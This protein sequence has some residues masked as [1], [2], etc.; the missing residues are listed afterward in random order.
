MKFTKLIL[1]NVF[2]NKLRAFLTALLIATIF[3]FVATLL[4]IL[5]AFEHFSDSGKGYNRLAVQSA[6]SL[7]TPLPYSHEPKLRQIP[8][9][10]DVCK[11]QWIGGIY[12]D[13]KNFFANFAVDHD[14]METVFEDY[15]VD[16]KQMADFKNDRQGALIGDDLPKRFGWKIGDRITLKGPLFGYDPQITIR[17]IYHHPVNKSALYYHMDYHQ[18]MIGNRGW[19]GTYWLNVKDPAQMASISQQI[20]AMFKN[21]EFPTE[22]F[23]EKE[24]QKN[25]V[26]MMGNI[27]LMFTVICICAIFMVVLLAAITMSMTARERVTEI[28]VLKAIGFQRG[29]VMRL[30][31]TEFVVLTLFGGAVGAFGA[32]LL[33][34]AVDMAQATQGFLTN[35]TVPTSTIVTCLAI[36]AG[37]GLLS[38]GIPALRA[39]GM[40]VVNGLRRV[41]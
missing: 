24:F 16:P 41:V 13:P 35:F 8:G 26:S 33:F 5:Y 6:I 31:L 11:L 30:M 2:R 27:K 25:F 19:A 18:Q 37:I 7:A 39:T 38:G 14:H 20:D 21:S 10:I 17:G 34:G 29:L 22:T 36:S 1:R 9:I 12:K 40:S 28:A 15:K 23:T 32:R 4:S 3:F